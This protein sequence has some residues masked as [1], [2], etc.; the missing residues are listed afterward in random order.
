MDL[1]LKIA[2]QTT[3]LKTIYKFYGFIAVNF[4]VDGRTYMHW[5]TIV[6][7]YRLLYGRYT[8]K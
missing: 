1:R 4:N 2:Q 3:K 8:S 7:T 5:Y 6:H